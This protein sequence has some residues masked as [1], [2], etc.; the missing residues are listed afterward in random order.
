MKEI[1]DESFGVIV[2]RKDSDA[3]RF[4]L[5]HQTKGHW[6]FPKGHKEGNENDIDAVMR[7]LKEETG[8][9]ECDLKTEKV[10]HESYSFTEGDVL[11]HKSNHYYLGY[12]GEK[13]EVTIQP[14]EI[15]EYAFTTYDEAMEIFKHKEPKKVLEEVKKYLENLDCQW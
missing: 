2:I 9:A 8:I 7:E 12:V 14:E 3:D 13:V 15:S 6:S 11:V 4:L 10:F 5:L 1:N